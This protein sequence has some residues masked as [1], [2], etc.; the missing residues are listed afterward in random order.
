MWIVKRQA[1]SGGIPSLVARYA[2]TGV[3]VLDSTAH[4][5]SGE[6]GETV[7]MLLLRDPIDGSVFLP[8]S[9]LAGALR[10]FLGDYLLGYGITESPENAREIGSL[11]GGARGDQNSDKSPLTVF[12]CRLLVQ[13][14]IEV[15]DGVAISP[16][17][18]TAEEGHKYD[19][20]VLPRGTRFSLHLE[21][22]I[23]AVE[24]EV[25]LLSMLMVIMRGLEEGEI[26]LGSRRTRGFGRCHVENWHVKRFDLDS[27]SGWLDW[28]GTLPEVNGPSLADPPCDNFMTAL[29]ATAPE[30]KPCISDD[31]RQRM[32]VKLLL[33]FK[34]G[35]LVRSNGITPEAADV[36]H[37]VSAKEALLPGTSLAGVLRAQ[38]SRIAHVVRSRPG[39]ADYWVNAVFGPRPRRKEDE[40]NTS[41]E[42]RLR[43]SQIR[44]SEGVI[45]DGVSLR[46]N[47]IKIDRFTGGV[48]D[49][50]LFDEEPLYGGQTELHLELRRQKDEGAEEF[51][52]KMG[53]VLLAVKDLIAGELNVGGSG[54]VGR[55]VA[56]GRAIVVCDEY[57][58]NR[59]YVIDSQNF[60]DTVMVKA[61]N[62]LVTAFARAAALC[63]ASNGG[64]GN[65]NR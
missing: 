37:I 11:F 52:A 24:A 2:I 16:E 9:S 46:V 28:L 38:A 5:G 41:E 29:Q 22:D 13:P 34:D 17:T 15:R 63:N 10:S 45:T 36:S 35:L 50:G 6:I 62:G 21:L 57:S 7:D 1:G 18:G 20:E 53:L 33:R 42:N 43:A 27:R 8:G 12:D 49:T 40:T 39:D 14:L 19:L 31:R 23:S 61:L 48:I 55:G 47:R 25:G 44:V 65:G 3:L 64:D 60:A 51:Q 26:P 54:A 4:F 32:L 30:V 56:E 58:R 59:P